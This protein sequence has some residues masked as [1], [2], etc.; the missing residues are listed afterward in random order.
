MLIPTPPR[1]PPPQEGRHAP[2]TKRLLAFRHYRRIACK[3]SAMACSRTR[4]HWHRNTPWHSGGNW[5][6]SSVECA[7]RNF[8]ACQQSRQRACCCRT[9]GCA[10]LAL[11]RDGIRHCHDY[12]PH[13]F[14]G[15]GRRAAFAAIQFFCTSHGNRRSI[16]AAKNANPSSKVNQHC[17]VGCAR[18]TLRSCHLHR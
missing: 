14:L 8:S 10:R 11:H 1:W 6:F 2:T 15:T 9:A 3:C 5:R 17:L 7:R 12:Q 4:I 16:Q 13:V 18:T